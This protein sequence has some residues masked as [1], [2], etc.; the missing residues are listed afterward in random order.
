MDHVANPFAYVA[1]FTAAIAVT[2]YLHEGSHWAVGKLGGTDPNVDWKIARWVWPEA[3]RHNEIEVMDTQLIR[4]SGLSI[5]LWLPPWILSLGYLAAD[6]TPW[7]MLVSVVPFLVVFAM[8]TESDVLAI[9][10]PEQYR[11]RAMNRDLPGDPLFNPIPVTVVF[12]VSASYPILP[13]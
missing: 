5:F 12:V 1:A 3:V 4:L 6:I 13:L 10:Q 9:R 8:A 7:T 11:K 2:P